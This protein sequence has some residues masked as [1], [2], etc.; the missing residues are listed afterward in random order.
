MLRSRLHLSCRDS[1]YEE[2]AEKTMPFANDSSPNDS[3]GFPRTGYGT[4]MPPPIRID[5][6]L[7]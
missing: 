7:D 4:D 6:R 3:K 1:A 5:R 2:T